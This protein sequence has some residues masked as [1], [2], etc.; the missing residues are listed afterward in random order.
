MEKVRNFFKRRKLF[1]GGALLNKLVLLVAVGKDAK[2][3]VRAAASLVNPNTNPFF[4]F[5]FFFNPIP[6]DKA[7]SNMGIYGKDFRERPVFPW[8]DSR[9]LVTPLMVSRVEWVT[10]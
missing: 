1:W 8:T 10:S 5:L 9:S 7:S 6:A 4:L 2:P 3:E